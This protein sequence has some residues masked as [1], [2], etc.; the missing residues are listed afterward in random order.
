MTAS[1]AEVL[2]DLLA[3]YTRF[4]LATSLRVA[5]SSLINAIHQLGK[6]ARVNP[7]E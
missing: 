6:S 2:F 1:I 5:G 7:D 4:E 3:G